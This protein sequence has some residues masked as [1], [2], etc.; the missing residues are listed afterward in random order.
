MTIFRIVQVLC[1]TPPTSYK[2]L[3]PY[4]TC[5]RELIFLIIGGKT[6]ICF[7]LYTLWRGIYLPFPFQPCPPNLVLVPQIGFLPI[8]GKCLYFFTSTRFFLFILNHIFNFTYYICFFNVIR[9]KLGPKVFERLVCLKD[10]IDAENRDQYKEVDASLS[11]ADTQGSEGPPSD[12]ECDPEE[13]TGQWYMRS[14]Y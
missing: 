6:K 13:E 5:T 10:W 3:I 11:G 2:S 1:T 12:D 9:S 8:K 4:R 7:Q 14:N